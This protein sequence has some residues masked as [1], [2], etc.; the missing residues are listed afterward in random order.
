MSVSPTVAL[1]EAQVEGDAAGTQHGVVDGA[2]GTQAHPDAGEAVEPERLGSP[3]AGVGQ[4]LDR[5]PAR[6]TN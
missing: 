5:S 4:L 3:A 1:R 6:S 2:L